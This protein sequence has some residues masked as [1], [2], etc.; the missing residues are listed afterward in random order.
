MENTIGDPDF[1]Q[2]TQKKVELKLQNTIV[3]CVEIFD[4]IFYK[5]FFK[6]FDTEYGTIWHNEKH[7]F[8]FSLQKTF[9]RQK[10]NR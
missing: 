10:H 1:V 2:W 8:A 6:V 7:Q 9:C 4:K 3:K 5:L